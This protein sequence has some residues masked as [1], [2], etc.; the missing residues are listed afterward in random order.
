MAFASGFW[1][2][3]RRTIWL[4]AEMPCVKIDTRYD[5]PSASSQG[6]R[7]KG[8]LSLNEGIAAEKLN[9]WIY[10]ISGERRIRQ[11]LMPIFPFY[12]C[13]FA[14]GTMMKCKPSSF[15]APQHSETK[16]GPATCHS[17][18][19]MELWEW[20]V[21]DNKPK[22]GSSPAN[23][24]PSCWQALSWGLSRSTEDL[25]KHKGVSGRTASSVLVN[26]MA[27]FHFF[28]FLNLIF[29]TQKYVNSFNKTVYLSKKA[30]CS[31]RE[32]RIMSNT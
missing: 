20:V 17:P 29:H 25:N 26:S 27:T 18:N 28:M 14:A 7:H 15:P 21:I 3:S 9:F 24:N 32:D 22:L 2:R 12:P 30:K 23:S 19:E 5:T 1:E 31:H 6:G 16:Q 4:N 13:S 11:G 10:S 8:L